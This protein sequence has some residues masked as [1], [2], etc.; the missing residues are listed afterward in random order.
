MKVD[1]M[2]FIDRYFGQPV[3]LLLQLL[4]W[5]FDSFQ[6]SRQPIVERALFIELSEMGS[7]VLVD[8]AMRWLQQQDKELFFV[9]FEKNAC[10]LDLLKTIPKENVFHLKPD[11]IWALL[12]STIR[13]LIWVR[14][15]NINTVVDLEL[16][17]RFT[18]ILTRLSGAKI[19]A[20]F[21]RV[22]EEGLYRGNFLTHPVMYNPHKHISKNFMTLVRATMF[23]DHQ[24]YQKLPSDQEPV[25]ARAEV[26][27]RLVDAVTVRL[28]K[29]TA[30]YRSGQS[31]LVLINPNGSDLVPQRRWLMSSYAEVITG[32][33]NQFDDVIVL[34]TG[35]KSERKAAEQLRVMVGNNERCINSAGV[36]SFEELVPLY[37]MSEL[38][39]SNDSGPPHFASVTDLRTYVLFGPETPALYGSMGNSVSIYADLPCSPCVSA[40]NHRKTSCQD[41]QCL[42]QITPDQ[43]L[44]LVIPY[45]DGHLLVK[46]ST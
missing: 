16:F 11:N 43:V 32:I 6:R 25:L 29:L 46:S 42:K 37:S 39:I 10:S 19:R 1:S 7:A 2:R 3:C 38:M 27:G 14:Q 21:H 9:I 17:S 28:Q 18:A 40:A 23:R 34:I 8:P 15:K 22:H 36:F 5:P 24:P 41:N 26:D 4:Y 30:L 44:D 45:L 35:S 13:F 20:G 31:R 12:F 33:L